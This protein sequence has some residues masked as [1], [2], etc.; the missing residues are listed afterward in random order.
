M[1]VYIYIYIDIFIYILLSLLRLR[2][3]IRYDTI[4]SFLRL[5]EL[6]ELES[7][8]QNKMSSRVVSYFKLHS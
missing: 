3:T 7:R 2:A 8:I 5:H 1:C 4:R 6:Y